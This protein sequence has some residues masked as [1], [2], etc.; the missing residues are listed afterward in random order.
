MLYQPKESFG[1]HESVLQNL[2]QYQVLV[3]PSRSHAAQREVTYSLGAVKTTSPPTGPQQV[4]SPARQHEGIVQVQ[5]LII[6]SSHHD[7][8][9]SVPLSVQAKHDGLTE[10]STIDPTLR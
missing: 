6:L 4:L 1:Q 9:Y 3:V 10:T 5:D 8:L 7:R 2:V